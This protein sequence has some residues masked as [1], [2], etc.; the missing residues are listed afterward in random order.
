M[1]E[2]INKV[3]FSIYKTDDQN[4]SYIVSQSIAVY[5]ELKDVNAG[6]TLEQSEDQSENR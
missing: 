3:K 5:L 2:N 6:S 1:S 4:T